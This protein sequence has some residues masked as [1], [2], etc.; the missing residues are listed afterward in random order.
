[1]ERLARAKVFFSVFRFSPVGIFPQERY[2]Y[3]STADDIQSKQFTTSINNTLNDLR[4]LITADVMKCSSHE[5]GAISLVGN[6]VDSQWGWLCNDRSLLG[7]S[8]KDQIIDTWRNPVH[9]FL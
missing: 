4:R 2:N 7:T 9:S 3:V 5:K 1:M 6:Y 8:K